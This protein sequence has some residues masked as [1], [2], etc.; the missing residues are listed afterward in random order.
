MQVYAAMIDRMDQGIGK[1]VQALRS[2]GALDN[3]LI[4]F[5]QDNGGCAEAM[6]RSKAVD[7]RWVSA[8][9]DRT[10]MEPSELQP[11]I[12][13]PMKTR[14]GRPV[15]GGPAVMPGPEDTY[16][17]YGKSW[18]NVSNTP[19]REYKHWVHEGGISTPLIVHWPA[20]FSARGEIRTEVGHLIDIMAT[21]VDVA[22]AVYPRV[23]KGN[24]ITPLEG[25]SL[26]PVFQGKKLPPRAIYWEHEANCAIRIGKWK[27]VRK[28]NM[29]T[30]ETRPWELYDME[31]D[32]AELHDL[33]AKFPERVKAMAQKWEAWA[34][35]AHVKPWPWG[36]RAKAKRR[37]PGKTRTR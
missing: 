3:T 2:Q 31:K 28:G 1:I 5:L 26:L 24:R 12:W 36:R 29:R 8:I 34:Q 23:Y 10:P 19:F 27:L 32:R 22:G 20:G 11:R 15:R 14:D 25:V 37:R 30:G 4:F 9:K 7:K 17:S 18:A 6:G 21:C 35:R 16:I 33:A 13:P